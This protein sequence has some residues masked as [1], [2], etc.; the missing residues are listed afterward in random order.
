MLLIKKSLFLF[1]LFSFSSILTGQNSDQT[2]I[3]NLSKS[4]QFKTISYKD[5]TAF[6]YDEFDAFINFLEDS[7]PLVHKNLERSIVN[8]YSLAYYWKGKKPKGKALLLMAHYDVVPIESATE[9]KWEEPPYSGKIDDQFIWGRGS[10][11]DKFSV[12]GILEATER[13]LADGF[14]PE[15]NICFA[16]GHDEEIGGVNGAKFIAEEFKQRNLIFEMVLDEGGAVTEGVFPGID[17]RM[18]FIATA[19]KGSLNLTL[20]AKAEGGH[21]SAPPAQT[22]IDVLSE[23]LV[24]LNN[25]PPPARLVKPVNDLF[26]ATQNYMDGKTKFALKNRKLLK[27]VIFKQ[28]AANKVTNAMIRTVVSPTIMHSGNAE[29]VLP[30][31][32]T[33]NLNI[34]LLTGDNAESIIEYVKKQLDNDE[35]KVEINGSYKNPSPVSDPKS[36]AFKILSNCIKETFEDVL[37]SPMLAI[38][39]TDSHHFDDIS[40]NTFRF[41]PIIMTENDTERI[42][43]SNERISKK[44]YLQ[45]IDFYK[46]VI[47]NFK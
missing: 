18:A 29:N 46:K 41:A 43:G 2:A 19:E 21:S 47:L 3:E 5:A 26:D 38:G 42:H 11:D 32:A 34:R 36:D 22:A 6:D 27:K 1:L 35:I 20:T 9:D 45:C 16:F 37:I 23:G 28:L 44:N 12:L 30:S 7:Y 40:E 15:K 25:N 8:K 13:L 39:G 33:A 10:L 17:N 24:K 31:V 4:I 14:Q